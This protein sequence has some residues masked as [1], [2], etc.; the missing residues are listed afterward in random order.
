M[1]DARGCLHVH[2]RRHD[3]IVTGGENVYP[4]EVENALEACPGIEE[5]G[6]FGM[7]DEVWG[8]TVVAV[9]VGD[10]AA[11]SPQ[12]LAEHVRAR[13]APHK[14]PRR[15]GFVEALPHT[16]AGKLDRAALPALAP[17]LEPLSYRTP[18]R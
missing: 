2:A 10:R 4:V 14:W 17:E 6:V 1:I 3:L 18:A 12:A 11:A 15:I 7:P 9:M 13:L 16:R 5:A 8:E